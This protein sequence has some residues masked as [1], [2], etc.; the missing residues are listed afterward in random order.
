MATKGKILSS[1][2]RPLLIDTNDP[3]LD[4]LFSGY[5]PALVGD[6]EFILY[7]IGISNMEMETS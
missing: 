4:K 2:G 6:D 7:P 5:V 1:Q 3:E